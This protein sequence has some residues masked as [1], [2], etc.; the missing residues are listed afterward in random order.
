MAH[1]AWRRRVAP[2]LSGGQE[3]ADV[4]E[5]VGGAR[6]GGVSFQ[7]EGAG[8]LAAPQ[9]RERSLPNLSRTAAA[10]VQPYGKEAIVHECD[11]RGAHRA[12]RETHAEERAIEVS[13]EAA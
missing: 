7:H 9:N 1:G 8:E 6:A 11:R 13:H 5:G 3:P 12:A 10:D 4:A 2:G